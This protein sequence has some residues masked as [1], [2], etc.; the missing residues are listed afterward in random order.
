MTIGQVFT[1]IVW[2]KWLLLQWGVFDSWI[3]GASICDPTAGIGSFAIALLQIAKEKGITIS[4]EMLKR[5]TLIEICPEHLHTFQQK[6]M[7]DFNVEFP[8]S[9]LIVQDIIT[10]S[11]HSKYDILVGNPPWANF[12]DLPSEYKKKIKSFFISEGLVPDRRK[13]L[14][15]SSRVDIAALILKIALG[16]LLQHKGTAYFYLPIS[17]F[18]G[19][20]A[21]TGFRNYV[22]N[23]RCF[24]VEEVREFNLTKV[25]HDV[26]TSYC[27][28]RFQIDT[29]QHFPVKYFRESSLGW[30]EYTALPFKKTD[31]QWRV[32]RQDD[33]ITLQNLP[34]IQLTK[35]QKPRQGINTCGANKV[36]IF[37]E[38]PSFLPDEYIYPLATRELW[39]GD[40]NHVYK[41]ILLPY[42]SNTGKPLSWAEIESKENLKNYLLSFK[43]SL[44]N[45]KGTLIQSSISKGIWWSLL[46]VGL[47]SFAPY[48]IIW[49]AYGQKEFKP[50]I[51]RSVQNGRVWQA[52]QAMQAFIP[53]WSEVD[54]IRIRNELL[55]PEIQ[56]LLKQ[57]NG[58]GRCN[59]AQPGKIKKII[60]YE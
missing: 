46:G 48:K 34:K 38:K 31:D 50:I 6:I 26:K 2:A 23:Q 52:N 5:L 30:V 36:F 27:C 41:W 1:P 44:E 25:F 16:R 22:A 55:N 51:L 60:S 53:S 32:I 40:V 37:D 47:Y 45:R 17:L 58:E 3:S 43:T 28:A 11:H 35:E 29:P 20:D 7:C 4:D 24:A 19:D 8:V 49:E 15:G 57:L 14:L 42:N 39:N 21:H 9:N 56:L 13:I 10:E 54:A 12:T 59:W 33:S 18:F